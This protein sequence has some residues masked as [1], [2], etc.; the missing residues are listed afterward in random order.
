[1]G[2]ISPF[3]PVWV[4][5]WGRKLN[6]NPSCLCDT[7]PRDYVLLVGVPLRNGVVTPSHTAGP[8][9]VQF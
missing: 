2:L 4:L 3:H 6:F 7:P 8:F 1:M 9:F 5:L